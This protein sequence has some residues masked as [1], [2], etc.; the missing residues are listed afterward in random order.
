MVH[1]M[2][3]TTM[4]VLIMTIIKVNQILGKKA[5]DTIESKN[6]EAV[7]ACCSGIGEVGTILVRALPA[8]GVVLARRRLTLVDIKL[9]MNTG[10]SI[11]ADTRV[12][13]QSLHTGLI[14]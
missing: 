4:T 6:T 14:D 7:K 12:I 1:K 5:I 8:G 11:M 9:T 13:L 3:T 2:L 10:V